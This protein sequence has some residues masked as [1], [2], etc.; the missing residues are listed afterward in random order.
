MIKMDDKKKIKVKF[1]DFQSSFDPYNN[2]FI[3]RLKKNFNVEI[4]DKPDFLFF[5]A[6]GYNHLDYDCVRIMWT[7]ENYVPDFNIADYAIAFE[8]IE[9]GD[10]YLRF[11]FYLE[12]N[13]I[14]NLKRTIKRDTS[15]LSE[16]T[17]FCS[18]VISNIW[19]DPYRI[20]FFEELC[21]YKKVNSGG[22][23]LNNIGGPIGS[24]ISDGGNV[25]NKYDFDL[26]HK[27]TIAMENS[28]A[29]GYTTEKITDAFAAKCI[30]IYW[31]DPK[32]TEEFN[33]KAF[34]NCNGLTIKEAVAKV[35]EVDNNDA[36]YKSMLQEPAYLGDM[37]K[38]LE[39]FDRFLFNICNQNKE[40]AYRRDRIMKGKQQ[41]HQYKLI[42]K[43]Y[44]KPYH[45]GIK[46][47]QKLHIE[48]IG[49]KIYH[50]IRD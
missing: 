32:I 28:Q 39:D 14:K 1:V 38:Y 26:Q 46:V 6:Y 36:L 41:E 37:N 3:D 40:E 5:G 33:P 50:K 16:K 7:I 18:F 34:I 19:G 17:E 45:F 4:S 22:R 8:I 2:F 25:D 47:A 12:P 31:G 44:Y 30:P 13:C 27:F 9:Y 21:K 42:N 35:K 11:P 24:G 49:R 23:S 48:F 43:Y 29:P 10:R 20:K 15:N